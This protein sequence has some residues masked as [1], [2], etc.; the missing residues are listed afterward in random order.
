[1]VGLSTSL[2]AVIVSSATLAIIVWHSNCCLTPCACDAGPKTLCNACGVKLVRK[3]R[4]AAEAK[5]RAATPAG[6]AD[7]AAAAAAHLFLDRHSPSP[8][9]WSN[10]ADSGADEMPLAVESAAAPA[11]ASPRVYE[12]SPLGLQQQTRRPV[13][14]AAAKAA[15][16]TAEYASTGDWPADEGVVPA[17]GDAHSVRISPVVDQSAW[18]SSLQITPRFQWHHAVWLVRCIC[19][20][21]DMG[22]ACDD[23]S[24]HASSA[25]CI[26]GELGQR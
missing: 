7:K 23:P 9:P 19:S 5:R 15:S 13:R 25:G 8:E 6:S 11:A 2:L 3:N 24:D 4:G 17:L 22:A 18:W 26:C 21:A 20:H 16:R 1:M 12:P 14:R 10:G